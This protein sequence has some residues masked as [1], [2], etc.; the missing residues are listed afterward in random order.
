MDTYNPYAH[1]T[2][3]SNW[4][5]ERFFHA[6]T[7]GD[8][9]IERTRPLEDEIENIPRVTRKTKPTG[10]VFQ[11]AKTSAEEDD[12]EDHYKSMSM[13]T[14]VQHEPNLDSVTR[15]RMNAP[16]EQLQC[17]LAANPTRYLCD[18]SLP[19]RTPE[20]HYKTVYQKSYV[21]HI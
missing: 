20:K 12:P 18:H 2:L 17:M 14:Y 4:Y 8:A 7:R 21:P 13:A 16:P 10:E 11:F 3:H 5:E 19:A 15:R 1:S 9:F 6:N